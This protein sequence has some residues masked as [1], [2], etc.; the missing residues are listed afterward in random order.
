MI[1]KKKWG[2]LA[3]R[4]LALDLGTARTVVCAAGY[5]VVVDEP[6][7]IAFDQKNGDYALC[8]TRR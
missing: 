5:G 1:F 8:D 2:I 7:L 6:S 4:D 3:D